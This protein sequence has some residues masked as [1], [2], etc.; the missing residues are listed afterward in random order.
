MLA[1]K[2]FT[3]WLIEERRNRGLSQ[4]RFAE[5]A[6]ISSRVYSRIERGLKDP[7]L[8]ICKA[9]AKVFKISC[10][11]VLAAAGKTPFQKRTIKWALGICCW[12]CHLGCDDL[13]NFDAYIRFS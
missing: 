4:K 8:R 3:N 6:G 2:E 7:S 5:L 12:L 1:N 11:E 10:E 9:I 13:E